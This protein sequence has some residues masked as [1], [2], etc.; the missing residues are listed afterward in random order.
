[1]LWTKFGQGA[2]SIKDPIINAISSYKHINV[3]PFSFLSLEKSG[4]FSRWPVGFQ[5][6]FLPGATH[7]FKPEITAM[8]SLSSQLPGPSGAPS[9]PLENKGGREEATQA[10]KMHFAQLLEV[11]KAPIELFHTTGR[12]PRVSTTCYLVTFK[13]SLLCCNAVP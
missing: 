1:M 6:I 4:M 11:W 5:E 9:L 7:L 8:I 2:R 3:P 10:P 13:W 12:N